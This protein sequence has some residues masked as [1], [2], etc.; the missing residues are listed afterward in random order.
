MHVL[1]RL[2]L[3]AHWTLSV[4]TIV[5]H[6]ESKELILLLYPVEVRLHV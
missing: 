4:L 2:L 5:N 3:G 1:S 6:S